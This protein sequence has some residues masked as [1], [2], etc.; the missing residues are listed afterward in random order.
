MK[1]F[2]KITSVTVFALSLTLSATATEPKLEIKIAESRIS[3]T[4]IKDAKGDVKAVYEEITKA[5]GFVP[6]V[7][8]QYSLNPK[9]LRTQWELYKELGNNKNFDPKMLTMMRMI[10]GEAQE[11]EYCTGLNKGM[12]LNMFKVPMDEVVALSKDASSAKLDAKQKAML[13]FI[14]K[15]TKTPHD[16]TDTEIKNLTKLGWSDK[17]IFEGIKSGTN[18]I[19]ATTIIDVL[20]LQKD[21]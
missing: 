5:W 4:D 19:A 17:D 20:K 2:N 14:L 10:L 18:V 3:F 7:L 9:I 15:A 11:C 16:V 1:L 8:K 6:I 13:L 12:L 21:F